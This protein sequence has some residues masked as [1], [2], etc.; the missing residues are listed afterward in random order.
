MPP[1][2]TRRIL[3][4]R[5]D[6]FLSCNDL[7][8]MCD[9]LGVGTERLLK[10]A[11]QPQY[12]EFSIPKK[13]GKRR[14]IEDPIPLLKRVQDRLGDFL[15]AVYYYNKTDSAYGFVVR[16]VD[17]L[18]ERHVLSN[19]EKH[20]N[21]KWLLNL[22][23]K[24]FFHLIKEERLRVLFGAP[25][26]C[27]SDDV[28]ILLAK[29]VTYK[30]RLP[31]GA[32]TSPVLSNLV[33]IPLD[34]DLLYLSNIKGW[35][36]TRYADDMSFSSDEE[37]TDQ[38]IGEILRV[39]HQWDFEINLSKKK[40]FRPKDKNKLV[41]GLVV[42]GMKVS[43]P[44]DYLPSLESAIHHLSKVIDAQH[45]VRSGRIRHS[46]WVDDLKNGVRGKLE[47]AKH[48]LGENNSWVSRLNGAY[49]DA[50]RP[51]EE[52]GPLSWLEFGYNWK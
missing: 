25:L 22:D 49:Y 40:L 26:F 45:L 10:L 19:A 27:F 9:I 47:F 11:N 31:M 23:M 3:A 37:I 29:I 41:T 39:V 20:V 34:E 5:R 15:N 17:D 21:K 36:Y 28:S 30:G 14:H 8:S 13:N 33:S 1:K 18:D 16:P 44:S 6:I 50:T 35:Q 42:S 2:L 43:L 7:E 32:P 46:K 38:D 12:R 51:P 48:I 4:R 24:D 52:Y